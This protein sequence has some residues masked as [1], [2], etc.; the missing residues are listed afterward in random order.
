M[1]TR[2][3]LFRAHG[4]SHGIRNKG[5]PAVLFGRVPLPASGAEAT[6]AA[7]TCTIDIATPRTQATVTA[8][9]TFVASAGVATVRTNAAGTLV[10][11]FT[12]VMAI[13][14]RLTTLAVTA[15]ESFACVVA[16]T[17]SRT[18]LAGTVL[19]TFTSA[20]AVSTPRTQLTV[21][22][23]E[24]FATQLGVTSV[25]TQVSAQAAATFETS[26]PIA[27]RRTQA[28]ITA[29]N[30]SVVVEPPVVEDTA[31]GGGGRRARNRARMGTAFK[32]PQPASPASV[33]T[34][35]RT[36]SPSTRLSA[37][38]S[39]V[40]RPSV[41][42]VDARLPLTRVE[43]AAHISEVEHVGAL[44]T[45]RPT[46]A[47]RPVSQQAKPAPVVVEPVIAP[48]AVAMGVALRTAPSRISAAAD[49][50]QSGQI[51]ELLTFESSIVLP[52]MRT[53]IAL[54]MQAPADLDE[55]LLA[56]ALLEAAA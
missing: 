38:M 26:L 51:E 11:R 37:A 49:V 33:D 48:A 28:A 30:D 15:N 14:S 3:I 5:I 45:S 41:V 24:I 4:Q 32:L 17:P 25:R 40:P 36:L 39:V 13:A 29:D 53:S 16:I 56:I 23:S 6:P 35:I 44:A 27:T 50:K 10:E 43:A 22:A 34:T 21:N 18:Q 31:S 47:T 46:P 19:E 55:E 20:I 1:P 54:E 2:P 42:E 7:N 52:F 12:A 8:V 9:E